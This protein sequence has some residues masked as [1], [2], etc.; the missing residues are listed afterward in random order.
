MEATLEASPEVILEAI[1]VA[2]LAATREA[3]LEDTRVDRITM[4]LIITQHHIMQQDSHRLTNL[5][6]SQLMSITLRRIKDT[7]TIIITPST[8]TT[9]IIN[10]TSAR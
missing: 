6:N 7:F 9:Q 2:S 1:P 3:T 10:K 8:T 4:S 5:T